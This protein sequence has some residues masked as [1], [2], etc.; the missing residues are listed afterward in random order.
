[1]DLEED[2]MDLKGVGVVTIGMEVAMVD[3]AVVV[4]VD[5][6]VAIVVSLASVV[7]VTSSKKSRT[8]Y[9]PMIHVEVADEDGS[10]VAVV[11]V[12]EEEEAGVDLIPTSVSAWRVVK[13][14]TR[15]ITNHTTVVMTSRMTIILLIA[16][17]LLEEE[18]VGVEDPEDEVSVAAAVLAVGDAENLNLPVDG[19]IPKKVVAQK[20]ER[21]VEMPETIEGWVQLQSTPL[22]LSKLATAVVFAVVVFVDVAGRFR[23]ALMSRT[24]LHPR[25]GSARRT[26]KE[27]AKETKA[28][29][30]PMLL[31]MAARAELG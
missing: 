22:Q 8:L 20:K 12:G 14:I 16:E 9:W 3:A 28:V 29:S 19:I 24:F 31:R 7:I 1:M 25:L 18:A 21:V 26:A 15:N 5:A 23:G 6:A 13:V 4:E 10:T 27:V 17:A 11:V 2:V 30:P